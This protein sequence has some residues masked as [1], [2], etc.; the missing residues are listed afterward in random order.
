MVQ[1][2]LMTAQWYAQSTRLDYLFVMIS[3][4]LGDPADI[5]MP[6]VPLSHE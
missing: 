4:L 1:N 5:L 6:N 2:L 3:I